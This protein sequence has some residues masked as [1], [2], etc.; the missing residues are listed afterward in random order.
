M[1]VGIAARASALAPYARQAPIM[2]RPF[3]LL[4]PAPRHDLGDAV[5]VPPRH[6][7]RG[8]DQESAAADGRIAGPAR[9]PEPPFHRRPTDDAS[10]PNHRHMQ[11][12]PTSPDVITSQ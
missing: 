11:P 8:Q 9:F 6:G 7:A 12:D 5:L 3:D 2:D 4:R 10:H 1:A